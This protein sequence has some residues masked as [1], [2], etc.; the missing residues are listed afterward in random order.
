MPA[1]GYAV[2]SIHAQ[3]GFLPGFAR[4]RLRQGIGSR[5]HAAHQRVPL[6]RVVGLVESAQLHPHAAIGRTGHQMHRLGGQAQRA[7][8]TALDGADAPTLGVAHGQL[9]VAP[10][11]AAA[12][13]TQRLRQGIECGRGVA[14]TCS[15]QP[16]CSSFNS[17]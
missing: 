17:L 16:D 13:G 14:E 9:L 11:P 1:M 8:G 3:A 7:H 6:A 15:D 2:Q 5:D 10:G 12:L 4:Q